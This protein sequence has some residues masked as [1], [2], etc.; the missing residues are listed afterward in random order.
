MK[1]RILY[2]LTLI[3]MIYQVP[4][5]G[6]QDRVKSYESFKKESSSYPSIQT[7][8]RDARVLKD[9]SPKDALNKVQEALGL[10]ITQNDAL[11][12]GR[13]YVLLGEINE[14]IEEWKLALDNYQN[15]YD[16]LS[17]QQGK[18]K[19]KQKEKY[20][21]KEDNTGT[22]EYRRALHGLGRTN[23]KL[24]NYDI[25]LN[26]LQQALSLRVPENEKIDLQLD[27]SEI[28]YQLKKYNEALK[29]L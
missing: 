11:N 22:E 24:G 15:A 9:K 2:L 8:L 4:A 3:L 13:S 16:K 12:E 21:S 23:A 5:R 25:A 14:S 19:E 26:F 20:K 18:E 10:S 6:Q 17:D 1:M 7:L 29:V 28:Y 27:I